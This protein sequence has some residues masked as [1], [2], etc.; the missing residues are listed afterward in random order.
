MGNPPSEKDKERIVSDFAELLPMLR[1]RVGM[2]QKDLGAKIGATRQTIMFAENKR[3]TLT[4][5]MF[6]TLAFL[7]Y[8]D[9]RT[10]PYM[11][12]SGVICEELSEFLF[13]DASV[14]VKDEKPGTE[15]PMLQKAKDMIDDLTKDVG[16]A[17]I[18]ND[19]EE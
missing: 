7:F 12:A 2:T 4:W 6:L 17:V 8:V 15:K 16:S 5:S 1:A 9:P 19:D 14:L 3:R 10:K 11:M 13:G 18:L